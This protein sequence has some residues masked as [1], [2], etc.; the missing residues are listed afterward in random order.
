MIIEV[1]F[2]DL[3]ERAV[4]RGYT[5]HEVMGCVKQAKP[6]NIVVVDTDHPKYPARMKRNAGPGTVLKVLLARLGLPSVPG[7]NCKDRALTMNSWGVEKCRQEVDTISEWLAE[8]AKKMKVPYSHFLG[9][10]LILK[11]CT[12]SE[13]RGSAGK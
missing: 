12:I 6:K 9:K 13:K 11:A 5:P 7:C 10:R 2:R 8:A 1:P 3:Y 4:Q